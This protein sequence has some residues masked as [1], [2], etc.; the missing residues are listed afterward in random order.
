MSDVIIK[1]AFISTLPDTG[2]TTKLGPTAWNA[3]RLL[4]G[5][6]PGEVVRRDPAAATGA[7]WGSSP[8]K[9]AASGNTVVLP[10]TDTL[11]HPLFTTT[12]PAGALSTPGAVITIASWGMFTGATGTFQVTLELRLGSTRLYSITRGDGTNYGWWMDA[13]IIAAAAANTQTVA[14]HF[15]LMPEPSYNIYAKLQSGED[16]AITQSLAIN[17]SQ[18]VAP[19]APDGGIALN[20]GMV[21]LY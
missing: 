3:A 17:G 13:T 2:D 4:S 16:S 10:G 1:P 12:V 21:T 19:S 20:G 15:A 8:R 6:N 11:W 5:G 14:V 18:E 7:S 9:L